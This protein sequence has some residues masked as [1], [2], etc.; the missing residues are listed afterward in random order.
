M[1]PTMCCQRQPRVS[2]SETG[3]QSTR[4]P[5]QPNSV[6]SIQQLH[7]IIEAKHNCTKALAEFKRF[8]VDWE[9]QKALSRPQAIG[10]TAAQ[11]HQ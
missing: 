11:L 5:E 6:S 3:E 7:L 2:L 10:L 9:W 4:L 8:I 1:Q